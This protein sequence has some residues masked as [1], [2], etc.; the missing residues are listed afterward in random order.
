[1]HNVSHFLLNRTFS[2][3][4]PQSKDFISY[5]AKY[6][7]EKKSTNKQGNIYSCKQQLTGLKH[8][9]SM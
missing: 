7:T 2:V 4:Q 3:K 6:T 1:L 8:L 9:P 5:N